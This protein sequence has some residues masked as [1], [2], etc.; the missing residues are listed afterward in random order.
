MAED[1]TKIFKTVSKKCYGVGNSGK[2][3]FSEGG[4][5]EF[6]LLV[7]RDGSAVPACR[8]FNQDLLNP[9]CQA[10]KGSN[11]K[12]YVYVPSRNGR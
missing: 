5:E 3:F 7:Y 10:E 11:V 2:R 6:E 8:C 9:R 4:R 12:C 1:R